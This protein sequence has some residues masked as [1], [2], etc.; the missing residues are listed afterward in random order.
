MA[1]LCAISK[2]F[3]KTDIIPA[4]RLTKLTGTAVKF[5]QCNRGTGTTNF[6]VALFM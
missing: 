6:L 4:Y 1:M 2:S 3:S 5:L